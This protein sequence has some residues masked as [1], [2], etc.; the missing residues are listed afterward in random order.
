MFYSNLRILLKQ[1]LRNK[2]YTSI[3]ILGFSI[4]LMFV[5]LLSVYIEQE[6]SVD[7]FQKNKNRIF[8]MTTEKGSY[9]S[10]P[11]GE[12]IKNQFPEVEDYTRLFHR[13]GIISDLGQQKLRLDYLMVDPAFFKMFSFKMVEG[14]TGEVLNAKNS[15]VLSQ[16][17]AHKMFGNQSPMGKE[18]EV[19]GQ[20]KFI[21]TGIIENFPENTHLR[22]CDALIN[23]TVLAD[24]WNSKE[25]LTTDGNN[26]FSLYFIAKPNSNLPAKEGDILKEFKKYHWMYQRGYAKEVKM[27]PLSSIYFGEKDGQ[28]AKGNSQ[29]LIIVLSTISVLILFLAIINYINLSIAQSSLRSREIAVKKLLGSTKFRLFA[30]LITESV[31]IC[32]VAFNIALVLSKLAE[33]VFNHLLDTNLNLSS[34]FSLST[35]ML[36]LGGILLVGFI[37]GLI[38]A[39]VITRFKAVE[40]VRGSFR[41]KTKSVFSK[42]LISFQF[43]IAIA[44]I[45]CS[46]I[47]IK[48]TNF[49]KSYNIGFSKDN[50]LWIS[51]DISPNQKDAFRSEMK[52]IPNVEEVSFVAGSPIDGGNN[53]SFNYNDKPVSFQEFKVDSLFFKMFNINDEKTGVAYARYAVWLNQTAVRELSLEKLPK[54]FKF[55][56]TDLP[57]YGVV[58]DF[59]FRDL[60]QKIGPAII[61]QLGSD[62]WAWSIFIKLSGGNQIQTVEQIKKAYSSFT[63]GLPMDYGFVD[64]T[65]Y[66][67][68]QQEERTASIIGYF[69][70]LAII[71]SV[72]GIL[73]MATFYIQQRIK[74]IGIRKVNGAT[75]ILIT[76]MLNFDLIKWVLVAFVVACPASYYISDK[77]L[78]NFPYRTTASWWVFILSGLIV[79]FFALITVTWQSWRAALRNPVEALRH[80]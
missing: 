26:S 42:I 1:L 56:N 78:Q 16:S 37:S 64:D 72:M 38:P 69:S 74:E 66:K 59:H 71:I 10:A 20:F 17:F 46:W 13:E 31:V 11:T 35:S 21:V 9:F 79:L 6:L 5:I 70:L 43:T 67:W 48:Q 75:E 76:R 49:M 19:N 28:G 68:Y 52:K 41:R 2:T 23:F 65:I 22:A 60:H 55:Y 62:D 40:V 63:N 53:Q 77:W 36:Y 4:S 15:I 50:I 58:T 29:K 34:K 33:P 80:E 57:V 32:L 14:N 24:F 18:V 7:K 44:L 25:I 45:I 51:N 30:Q 39:Y 73:A 12:K 3:T 27:E 61:T 8:R 54:T 47:I